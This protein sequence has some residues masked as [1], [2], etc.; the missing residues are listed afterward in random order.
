MS[1]T[2]Q[3]RGP[4]SIRDE[5]VRN[6]SILESWSVLPARTRRCISLSITA[7]ALVGLW[8]SDRL[9]EA[10]PAT[11]EPTGS[12]EHTTRTPSS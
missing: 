8:V 5:P 9:E 3:R 4:R 10:I 2:P 12:P 7:V 6:R 1:Q 11:P